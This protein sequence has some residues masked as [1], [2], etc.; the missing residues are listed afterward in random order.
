MASHALRP[1]AVIVGIVVLI[2]VARALIV[3]EDFGSQERGYMFGFHRKANE[4]DWKHFEVKYAGSDECSMC[5]HDKYEM[6]SNSYHSIIRCENCHGPAKAHIESVMKGDAKP[7]LPEKHTERELC[8]R[9][10]AILPYMNSQRINL[11]GVDPEKHNPGV[12]C[13]D[14]HVAHNP[15]LGVLEK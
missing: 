9:C 10:H 13:K 1:L 14:C 2:L 15:S 5:H 12:N 11:R 7:L 3:P 8:L 4:D 6:I